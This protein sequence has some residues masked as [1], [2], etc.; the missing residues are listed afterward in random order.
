MSYF[1]AYPI[2]ACWE[3]SES[4]GEIQGQVRHPVMVSA[5]FE[6]GQ[7]CRLCLAFQSAHLLLSARNGR[8]LYQRDSGGRW[9]QDD[10]HVCPLQ[11]SLSGHKQSVVERMLELHRRAPSPKNTTCTKTGIKQKRPL[12]S[13]SRLRCKFFSSGAGR[14][15]EPPRSCLRRILSFRASQ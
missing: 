14:G 8:G 11:S 12:G 2:S 6:G 4:S 13:S 7:D 3:I 9:T 1:S 10:H 5:L 15:V